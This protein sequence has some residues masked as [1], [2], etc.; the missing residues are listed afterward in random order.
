MPSDHGHPEERRER[1]MDDYRARFNALDEKERSPARAVALLQAICLDPRHHAVLDLYTA[2]RTGTWPV[3]VSGASRRAR[4]A[5][6]RESRWD[7]A[8]IVA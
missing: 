6:M 5:R 4:S 1:L 2:A 7:S 8:C 3:Q